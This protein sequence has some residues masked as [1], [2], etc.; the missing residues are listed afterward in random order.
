MDVLMHF[1]YISEV[2]WKK[3]EALNRRPI[4][5]SVLSDD[6]DLW[7]PIYATDGIFPASNPGTQIFHSSPEVSPWIRVDLKDMLVISFLRV[8]MRT[9]TEGTCRVFL[10]F[11]KYMFLKLKELNRIY[12]TSLASFQ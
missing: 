11:I 7:G 10:Q 12:Y 9:D 5:S 6:N 4:P 1:F 2:I 8:Y 3:N